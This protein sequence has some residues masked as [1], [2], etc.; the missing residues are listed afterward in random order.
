MAVPVVWSARLATATITSASSWVTVYTVPT[1]KRLILKTVTYQ[2]NN[3]ATQSA[4]IGQSATVPMDAALAVATGG[5]VSRSVWLVFDQGEVV[6]AF[7]SGQPFNLS[8][9]G[10]LLDVP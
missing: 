3:A 4:Y 10:Q 2:N 9:H 1:G 8:L 5:F 7:V 6:Q